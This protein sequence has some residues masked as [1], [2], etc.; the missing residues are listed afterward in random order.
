M[1]HKLHE[2][3]GKHIIITTVDGKVFQGQAY[4]YISPQDNMPAI[5]SITIGDVELYENEII[6]I[7]ILE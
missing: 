2:Y 5:A 7:E 6:N 3:H 1:N 4:D